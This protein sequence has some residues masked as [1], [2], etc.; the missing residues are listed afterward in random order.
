MQMKW[1]QLGKI[2]QSRIN[3]FTKIT[4]VI[5]E[6]TMLTAGKTQEWET[7][8]AVNKYKGTPG[9]EEADEEKRYSK[10]EHSVWWDLQGY[11]EKDDSSPLWKK[12]G[13]T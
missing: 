2:Q 11:Q 7:R 5:R 10:G 9:D 6:A 13:L 1:Q 3:L 8:Q 4:K 12:M